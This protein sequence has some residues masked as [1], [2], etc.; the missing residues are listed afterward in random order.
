MNKAIIILK[1]RSFHFDAFIL[2]TDSSVRRV[3][4]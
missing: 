1:Y 3:Q 2:M 4:C